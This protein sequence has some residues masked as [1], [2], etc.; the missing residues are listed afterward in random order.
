MVISICRVEIAM[1][2]RVRVVK[3]ED[4]KAVENSPR[5]DNI[6]RGEQSTPESVVKSWIRPRGVQLRPFSP[7]GQ[8]RKPKPFFGVDPIY[9]EVPRPRFCA[10]GLP[11]PPLHSEGP[12]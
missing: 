1:K 2:C 11:C 9:S 8:A 10:L 4:R 12:K 6:T 5:A 3:R 7:T